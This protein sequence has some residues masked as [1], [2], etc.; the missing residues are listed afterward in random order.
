MPFSSPASPSAGIDLKEHIGAL[1]LIDVQS[2]EVGIKT[3]HG[4]NDAI[5]CDVH[6]LDGPGEGTSYDGTLIFPK[7]LVGQLKRSIGEKVLGRLGQ[8]VAKPGQ[9]APWILNEASVEDIAKA[10]AWVASNKPSV[11]SAQ[12]PF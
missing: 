9:S 6:V 12:A 1:L 8:G 7:V 4:D 5:S 3:V 11:T 2:L 10:E